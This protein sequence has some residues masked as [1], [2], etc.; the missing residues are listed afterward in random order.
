MTIR[1]H[2]DVVS[3]HGRVTLR[4]GNK[5]SE[6]FHHGC[7]NTKAR[8]DVQLLRLAGPSPTFFGFGS[9]FARTVAL[10]RDL[11]W[12]IRVCVVRGSTTTVYIA[13]I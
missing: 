2:Y 13:Y 5:T 7:Y 10:E 6:R 8:R 11:S 1:P 12:H 9:F 3:V 4:K